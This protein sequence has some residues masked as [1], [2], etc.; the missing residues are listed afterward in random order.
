M[1]STI[2]PDSSPEIQTEAPSTSAPQDPV[3]VEGGKTAPPAERDKSTGEKAES[4]IP[5]LGEGDVLDRLTNPTQKTNTQ[6]KTPEE[7]TSET[8]EKATGTPE[9][10]E[11]AETEEEVAFKPA[12]EKELAGYH[13]KTRRRIQQYQRELDRAKASADFSDMLITQ[14]HEIGL[15]GENIHQWQQL[16]FGV[17]KKDPAALAALVEV[18]GS[19]GALPKAQEFDAKPLRD[20]VEKLHR[21]MNLD[22]DAKEALERALEGVAPGKQAQPQPTQQHQRQAQPAQQ[23]EI[24]RTPYELAYQSTVRSIRNEEAQDA[25]KYGQKYPEINKAIYAEAARRE[26]LLPPH[27]KNDPVE[28]RVRYAAC[29]E[30]VLA[31]VLS[32]PP[33]PKV[34]S[35]LRGSGAPTPLKVPERGTEEYDDHVMT[36]GVP[37]GR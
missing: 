15:S 17:R 30:A 13:S 19:H 32:R 23:P 20:V 7:E 4:S 25:Q 31:K 10:E 1:P 27:I 33:Q 18:L 28:M 8:P 12:D 21:S 14:G 9:T 5:L 24:Q 37:P 36:H 29:R 16:G 2:D 3:S 22:D 11:S 26:A 6:E 34:E 35:S